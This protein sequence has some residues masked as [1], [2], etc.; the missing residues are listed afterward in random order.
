MDIKKRT[1]T[2]IEEKCL[3]HDLVDIQNWAD[4]AID[5]K[6]SNCR[7]R[8]LAEWEPILKADPDVETMPADDD[9]LVELIV[10]RD[11]YK[12]R[13]ERDAANPANG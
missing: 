11:D 13:V 9:K 3:K 12:N 4:L 5:G 8:M 6:V 2:T 1:L 10:A 7:K